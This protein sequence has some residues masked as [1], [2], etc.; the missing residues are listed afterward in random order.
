[1]FVTERPASYRLITHPDH[2]RQVGV[3]ARHWG[4]DQFAA[5]S[6]G[7]SAT[8][9]A[10]LHDNGWW[11]PDLHPRVV[12]GSPAGVLDVPA[13]DWT[14]FYTL[15]VDRTAD[16]DAY[17]AVLVSMHGV[18]VRR[19]RYGIDPAMP[20]YETEF[21]EYIGTQEPRQLELVA[22]M[23]ESDRL[24]E[25][26]GRSLRSFLETLHETGSYDDTDGDGTAAGD[27]PP[28]L[29]R[30]Y[31]RLQFWDR[32]SLHVCRN[33]PLESTAIGPVP[34]RAGEEDVT[35]D[36]EPVDEH[37]LRLDPYPFDSS[38]LA[39]PV[40]GREVPREEYTRKALVAA[41]YDADPDQF[42]FVVR[43]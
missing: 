34:T 41:Y 4:N 30:N 14:E 26:R 22:R 33:D 9:A 29:W 17:A 6:P 12:D 11:A 25:Q 36:V 13:D 39:V 7:T 24:S 21:A 3:F 20:N 42:E 19:Q 5:P 43:R 1:M 18:G 15:A 32:L 16:V 27:D 35:I 8:I 40:A 2:S 38:P 23:V 10:E 28:P 31:E 37:T